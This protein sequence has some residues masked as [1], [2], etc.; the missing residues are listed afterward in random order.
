MSGLV[1]CT[2]H[3]HTMTPPVITDMGEVDWTGEHTVRYT[4]VH[5]TVTSSWGSRFK[6][7]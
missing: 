3:G 5:L 4:G 6:V 1:R 2:W 7:Y